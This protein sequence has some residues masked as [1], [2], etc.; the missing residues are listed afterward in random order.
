MDPGYDSPLLD[1]FRRGT[2]GRDDRLLAAQGAGSQNAVEQLAL[3][4]LLSDDPDAEIASTATA[5]LAKLPPGSLARFLKR[6]DVPQPIRD[7]FTAR[8]TLRPAAADGP[9]EEPEEGDDADDPK[10][11]STL[12]VMQRMKIAMKGTAAQRAILIRDPNK[13]VSSA[14]LGSPK[15]TEAEIEAFARMGNVSE[16]VLRTIGN[17]RTWTKSYGVVAGLAR[18]PKTPPAISMQMVQ[19][20]NER[21]MKALSTDRNVPEAVRLLARRFALKALD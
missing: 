8:G 6:A 5:T 1:A 14:V 18:N 21:D 7:F 4:V 16:E 15:L 13:M 20:L 19:R 17:N 12:S 2:V 11:L 3:L 10:V 9:S